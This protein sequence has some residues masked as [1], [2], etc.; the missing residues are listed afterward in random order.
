MELRFNWNYKDYSIKAV[1][2]CLARFED[3][4]IN[5][6]IELVKWYYNKEDDRHYCF[7]LAYWIKDDD[8]YFLNFVG[9]RPFEEIDVLDVGM[10]WKKLKEA[11]KV[12][13]KFWDEEVN[14]E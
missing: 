6:T 10:V 9:G 12:L 11:Q 8:G 7:T 5:E 3:S 4:D 13:D 1:P 2:K 14:Y